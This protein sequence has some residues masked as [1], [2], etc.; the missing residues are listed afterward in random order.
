MGFFDHRLPVVAGVVIKANHRHPVSATTKVTK[1]RKPIQLVTCAKSNITIINKFIKHISVRIRRCLLHRRIVI[2]RIYPRDY[3]W[4]I[5]TVISNLELEI[6]Y[7]SRAPPIP[8]HVTARHYRTPS[9]I[10]VGWRFQACTF[11]T[12]SLSCHVCTHSWA[13]R[14]VN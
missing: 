2:S 1:D 10:H 14:A 3:K 5:I 11:V 4:K 9:R 12:C 8:L 13:S 6:L 7:L